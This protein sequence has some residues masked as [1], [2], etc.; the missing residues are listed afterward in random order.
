MLHGLIEFPNFIKFLA[1]ILLFH[2]C[3]TIRSLFFYF[4]RLFPRV[5]DFWFHGYRSEKCSYHIN[6]MASQISSC[7]MPIY[8]LYNSSYHMAQTLPIILDNL[9]CVLV[10]YMIRWVQLRQ[11]IR[12]VGFLWVHRFDMVGY[13]TLKERSRGHWHW[14]LHCYGVYCWSTIFNVFNA[15]GQIWRQRLKTAVTKNSIAVCCD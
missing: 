12:I 2:S 11:Y 9:Y 3:V 8:S 15:L 14:D 5:F 7:D 1:N 6:W 10:E 4:Y 13:D